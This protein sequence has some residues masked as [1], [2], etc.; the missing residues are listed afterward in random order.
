[1]EETE[2]HGGTGNFKCT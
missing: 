1:M 2:L